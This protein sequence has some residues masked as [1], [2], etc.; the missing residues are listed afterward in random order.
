MR[1][2]PQ[3]VGAARNR[4]RG[5][6]VRRRILIPGPH[7]GVSQLRQG[8]R[9]LGTRRVRLRQ[10]HCFPHLVDVDEPLP[11]DV[12]EV[13]TSHQELRGD[14]RLRLP[15]DSREQRLHR[16][17]LLGTRSGM[18][19]HGAQPPEQRLDGFRRVG[20]H[21]AEVDSTTEQSQLLGASVRA[22]DQIRGDEGPFVG[23]T[24]SFRGIEVV[25]DR[26]GSGGAF[27]GLGVGVPRGP[28]LDRVREPCM[29]VLPVLLPELGLE[30]LGTQRVVEPEGAVADGHERAGVHG[31]PQ[32]DPDPTG[33]LA[34]D[35]RKLVGVRRPATD[36]QHRG[37]SS[38]RRG[39][40][41]PGLQ[42]GRPEVARERVGR[43]ARLGGETRD[44]EP[45]EVRIAARV[46]V[47]VV[48]ERLVR[49]PSEQ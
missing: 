20:Q 33:L 45:G 27:S 44:H 36:R 47:H 46:T 12:A 35:L 21:A 13:H 22:A 49:R 11:G 2:R 25:G 3:V 38:R 5:A 31:R 1:E 10:G 48:Y 26:D 24:R 43:R 18:G 30:H 9:V 7:L 29:E 4:D 8:Q 14:E 15:V 28:P 6:R 42:N 17:E 37:E 32:P 34:H 39:Q 23:A 19:G 16:I 41:E 40:P